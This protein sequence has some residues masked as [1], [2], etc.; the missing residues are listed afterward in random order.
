[1]PVPQ[2]RKFTICGTGILHQQQAR[3]LFHKKENSLFVEQ[4]SCLFLKM[5]Q[6][7]S[8]YRSRASKRKRQQSLE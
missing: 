6:Y 7:V 4:A 8:L 3:C 1:M 2:E 5:L